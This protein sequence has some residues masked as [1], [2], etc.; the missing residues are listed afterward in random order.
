MEFAALLQ[1]RRVEPDLRGDFRVPL[2]VGALAVLATLPV[3][4]LIAAVGLEVQSRQIG[5]PGVL[6][7]TALGLL[8]PAAYPVLLRH[9]VRE[10]TARVA[11]RS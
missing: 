2:G 7:A 8:G 5:L 1:L 11:A 4:L 10:E 9:R 6:V 3:L